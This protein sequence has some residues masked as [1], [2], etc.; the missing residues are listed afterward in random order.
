MSLVIFD[1]D[2]VLVDSEAIYNAAEVQFLAD[3]GLQLDINV[4]MQ[5]FMGMA[6]D[7][8]QTSLTRLF[9]D[10]VGGEL[11][12]DFFDQLAQHTRQRFE[13]ELV[14]VEGARSAIQDLGL[15]KCVASSSA[16]EL[17]SWKLA[18]TGLDTYFQPHLFST[19]LVSRGKPE[20]DLFL[21]AAQAMG[22]APGDCFVVED[23]CNGVTA[24]KRAG[25][26]TIGFT[27]GSHCPANHGQAL[28]DAGADIV[29]DRFE[30]LAQTIDGLR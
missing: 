2:G 3:A 6:A 10:R 28:R 18:R 22:F 23:S 12:P 26:T 9:S 27:A 17:L 11:A 25:M 16:P 29:I 7:E 21:H 14:A 8:W 1:C 30:G 13:A 5:T 19:S 15:P 4:Y 24:G 20:P